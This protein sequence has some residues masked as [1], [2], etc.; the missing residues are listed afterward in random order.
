MTETTEVKIKKSEENQMKTLIALAV[1]LLIL[2]SPLQAGWNSQTYGDTT[3]YSNSDGSTATAQTFGGT[4]YYNSPQYGSSS[5]TSY[6]SSTYC[7]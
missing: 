5:C 1:A 4:T 7:N 3:Y 2:S 6:G